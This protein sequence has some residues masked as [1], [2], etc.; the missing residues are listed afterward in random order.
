MRNKFRGW[1]GPRVVDPRRRRRKEPLSPDVGGQDLTSRAK[2][3]DLVL[4]I[5]LHKTASSY[6]QGVLAASRDDLLG[7]GLLYPTTGIVDKGATSTREGAGSGQGLLSRRG[8]HRVLLARLMDEV[9]EGVPTVL[10]SSEEFSRGGDTPSPEKLLDRFKPFRSVKVVLVLRR[11]DDWIESFYK[12]IVDQYGNFETRSFDDFLHQTGRRL[13]DFHTRFTPWRELVGPENFQVLSYDDLPDGAA[14]CRRLLEI[15]GLEGPI[16]DKLSTVSVPRYDSVRPIDTLGLRILNS[17]RLEDRT[18]RT[19]VA[20]SIYEVAPAGD[21][22]LM[23]ADLREGIQA[24]CRPINER[25]ETEWFAEPVP[26]F[27]FGSE[28]RTSTTTPPTGLEMV[29]YIDQVIALCE[30]GL[31]AARSET[32]WTGG[33]A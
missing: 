21:I 20:R 30:D 17:H 6:I 26:G 15:A 31:R 32:T 12:Q 4:H 18:I 19:G 13:L 25:I 14:I 10:I 23:T 27:R 16:L 11:Q 24:M 33:G 22:E 7:E 3:T 2:D 8:R 28:P 5:G 29:D 9:G 1:R